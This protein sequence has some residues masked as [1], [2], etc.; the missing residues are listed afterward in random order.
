MRSQRAA[1]RMPLAR[2]RSAFRTNVLLTLGAYAI[3]LGFLV[4][5]ANGGC[6]ACALTGLG[7]LVTTVL[8]SIALIRARELRTLLRWGHAVLAAWMWFLY[9]AAGVFFASPPE[10]ASAAIVGIAL[11]VGM[12]AGVL[13]LVPLYLGAVW[14]ALRLW[15]KPAPAPIEPTPP[16]VEIGPAPAKRKTTFE[17]VER[18]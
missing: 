12:G 8:A 4:L 1:I 5:P 10:D 6:G 7:S 17:L 18:K 3:H 16:L 13:S 15:P 2:G 9:G 14:L 11:A